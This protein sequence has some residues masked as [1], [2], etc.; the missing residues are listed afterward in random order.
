MSDMNI[1]S[2]PPLVL[3]DN[4]SPTF[5]NSADIPALVNSS[6]MISSAGKIIVVQQK[7]F[8]GPPSNFL[9]TQLWRIL[10]FPK[11][12]QI[13]PSP[14]DNSRHNRERQ[15]NPRELRRGKTSKNPSLHWGS[16]EAH[17]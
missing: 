15:Y 14:P 12:R 11:S 16:H 9:L 8:S 7:E 6:R 1:F 2:S 3:S 10:R 4:I 5:P 13:K 17:L